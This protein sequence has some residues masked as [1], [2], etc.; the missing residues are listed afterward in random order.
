M[1]ERFAKS[2]IRQ[3]SEGGRCD[4]ICTVKQLLLGKEIGIEG[5]VRELCSS[6]YEY[7]ASMECY[8]SYPEYSSY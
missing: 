8:K 2:G 1:N 3:L 7:L 5:F 6:N 4:G